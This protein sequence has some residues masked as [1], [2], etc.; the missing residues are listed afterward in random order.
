[1]KMGP[2]IKK[3]YK[4]YGI[5][6]THETYSIQKLEHKERWFRQINNERKISNYK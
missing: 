4:I 3:R 1:M 2:T 5:V 6:R